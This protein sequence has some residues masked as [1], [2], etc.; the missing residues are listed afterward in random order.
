MPDHL[1]T[2]GGTGSTTEAAGRDC[3]FIGSPTGLLV[4]L[5]AVA[6]VIYGMRYAA[7]MLNPILLAMFLVMG[8]SPFIHWLRRKGLPPWATLAVVLVLFVV[9][10]LLFQPSRPA[11]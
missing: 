10:V 2:Q 6:I 3:S 4:A 7:D 1:D 5:A 9:V 11:R 8:I